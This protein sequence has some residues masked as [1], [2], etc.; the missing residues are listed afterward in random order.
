MTTVVRKVRRPAAS[1]KD[2]LRD[3]KT[4]VSRIAK[5]L[6]ER[7]SPYKGAVKFAVKVERDEIVNSLAKILLNV[8]SE[9][10]LQKI[11]DVADGIAKAHGVEPMKLFLEDLAKLSKYADGP[12]VMEI[13]AEAAEG[14]AK[15]SSKEL[16]E[17]MEELLESLEGSHIKPWE[18]AKPPSEKKYNQPVQG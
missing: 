11:V 17:F 14:M 5:R 6:L 1:A 12:D 13:V 2:R 10:T 16:N 18:N 3:A 4:V 15:L 8:K 7:H 9:G